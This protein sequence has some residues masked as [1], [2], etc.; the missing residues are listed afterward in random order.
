[1]LMA[2]STLPTTSHAE[3]PL[4]FIVVVGF[5]TLRF[6][7]KM[8]V[9]VV[10]ALVLGASLAVVSS[11]LNLDRCTDMLMDGQLPTAAQ[12][13]NATHALEVVPFH[14]IAHVH[15]KILKSL[16]HTVLYMCAAD[17]AASSGDVEHIDIVRLE[18]A[19]LN[20]TIQ[21]TT[22]VSTTRQRSAHD[23][24][25]F[26]GL[27]N[28][29]A[30]G[31]TDVNSIINEVTG[32]WWNCVRNAV[33]TAR[34]LYR[35]FT[36]GAGTMLD[37]IH[38]LASTIVNCISAA[39]NNSPIGWVRRVWQ[40]ARLVLRASSIARNCGGL[41]NTY[42]QHGFNSFE[43]GQG[44]GRCINTLSR[45]RRE[46]AAQPPASWH[47]DP[48][49]YGSHDGCDVGCGAF[50]PDCSDA[51]EDIHYDLDQ[52]ID[53]VPSNITWECPAT[54]YNGSD[55]C[56]LGCGAWDPDCG[57]EGSQID[58][59]TAQEWQPRFA[60]AVAAENTYTAVLE[61]GSKDASGA[62]SHDGHVLSTTSI[63]LIV[64]GTAL[65]TMCVCVAVFVGMSRRE[66]AKRGRLAQKLVNDDGDAAA[67]TN[68]EAYSLH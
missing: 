25:F 3:Q 32:G 56:D 45:R 50:D 22:A 5:H 55:G 21:I 37:V 23:D 18:K 67:A 48:A 64:A 61:E 65:V 43:M 11:G 49:F 66:R 15:P 42:R 8:K 38:N 63:G 27:L 35:L 51:A 19:V 6:S 2:T 1:M 28:A 53:Y 59:S 24:T 41:W 47:C 29:L 54:F 60:M 14:N 30:D 33:S 62:S 68:D 57:P 17:D 39:T 12:Y 58:P 36:A 16:E 10:L 9:S 31:Q 4:L 40:A 46:I 44:V 34:D 26:R 20:R 52:H 13:V 7:L